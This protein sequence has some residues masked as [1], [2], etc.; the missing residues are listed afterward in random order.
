MASLIARK[1]NEKWEYS[2]ET[3]S[4]DGKRKRKS[5]GGFST[6]K[7]CLIAG[8]NALSEYNKTGVAFTPSSMSVSDYLDYWF[9]NYVLMNNKPSTQI[10]YK[11]AIDIAK[12]YI[13]AE[14]LTSISP[15]KMQSFVNSYYNNASPSD[16]TLKLIYSIIARS[17]N[18]AYFPYQFIHIDVCKNITL[19]K[20]K[21][22]IINK[23]DDK[24]HVIDK[25]RFDKLIADAPSKN[26]HIK[27]ALVLGFFTGMRIGEVFGLCWSDIDFENK[28]ISINKTFY[29]HGK[30]KEGI[31]ATLDIPKTPHSI[32]TIPVSDIVINEL[33]NLEKYNK[34]SKLKTGKYYQKY[35]VINNVI[36]DVD[37]KDFGAIPV[38]FI[39][40]L[41]NGTINQS[42]L[43]RYL[44]KN[45]LHF[46]TLRH[47][48]ATMLL[49]ADV[50]IKEISER[51][52]HS[53][54]QI[55]L[56]TYAKTT[57]ISRSKTVDKFEQFLLLQSN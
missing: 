22:N 33:K 43:K 7:E 29:F 25:A 16:K 49:E 8:N 40:R 23:K 15:I 48:H 57:E 51:L 30:I 12:N 6:K 19:T 46:H 4:I 10:I 1:R 2:F 31:S 34:E 3:A 39:F 35:T 42:P 26:P 18:M 54:I 56:D 28:L 37:Y 9:T 41:E 53:T 20:K 11:Y 38:D 32:R 45:N 36:Y 14:T 52:G 13:G 55:T 50:N 47:T 17:M 44:S 24:I 21:V 5:K 27:A